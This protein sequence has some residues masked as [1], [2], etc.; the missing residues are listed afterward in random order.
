MLLSS[1]TG[2]DIF[3]LFVLMSQR[4]RSCPTLGS[5]VE[6]RPSTLP[7]AGR[8]LFA[9]QSFEVGDLVTSYDGIVL[10]HEQVCYGFR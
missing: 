6:I 8:G 1:R 2:G 9:M 5:G 7:N 4:E 10:T 3:I